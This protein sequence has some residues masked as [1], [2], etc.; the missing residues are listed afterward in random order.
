[1]CVGVAE[2]LE[3]GDTVAE[4]V[5][6]D[7]GGD[8][9]TVEGAFAGRGVAD[10]AQWACADWLNRWKNTNVP[11]SRRITTIATSFRFILPQ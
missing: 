10:A 4:A 11:T 9:R 2:L 5:Q 6:R 1:M 3:N 7:C 8:S